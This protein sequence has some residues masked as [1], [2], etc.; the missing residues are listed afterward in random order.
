M[1]KPKFVNKSKILM[2]LTLLCLSIVILCFGVLSATSVNYTINGTINYNADGVYVKINVSVYTIA[3]NQTKATVISTVKSMES[4]DVNQ[5]SLSI[6][7]KTYSRTQKLSEYSSL[8][9]DETYTQKDGFTL[10]YGTYG[11]YYIVI[12]IKNLSVLRNVSAYITENVKADE[13]VIKTTNVYQN[14]IS[15]TQT[16]NIVLAY[17]IRDGSVS[18]SDQSVNYTINV[19]YDKYVDNSP[20]IQRNSTYSY[21]Y[22]TLGKKESTDTSENIKWKLVSLDDVTAYEYSSTD[23]FEMRYLSGAVFVQD[24]Y[25][26]KK[27]QFDACDDTSRSDYSNYYKSD[28]RQIVRDPATWNVTESRISSFIEKRN[29]TEI[30]SYNGSVTY[31]GTTDDYFWLISKKESGWGTS[32]PHAKVLLDRFWGDDLYGK[33]IYV[34]DEEGYGDFI[35]SVRHCWGRDPFDPM[36]VNEYIY[37]ESMGGNGSER[38]TCD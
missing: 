8:N 21:Y 34:Y 23:N 5:S 38:R 36:G 2:V 28:I 31:T 26:D 20:K 7:D 29:I 9:T 30:T 4:I 32:E 33:E 11:A 19:S 1:E 14:D 24:T 27:Y 3:E 17:S 35:V 18:V 12:N 13:N 15:S 37:N 6:S 22:I 25:V 16:K 10:N